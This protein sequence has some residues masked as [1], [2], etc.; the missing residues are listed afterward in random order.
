MTPYFFDQHRFARGFGLFP[1][2]AFRAPAGFRCVSIGG[3][4]LALHA[5]TQYAVEQDPSS[6]DFVLVVGY[7]MDLAAEHD[8]AALVAKTL[9][10]SLNVGEKR[11]FEKLRDLCGRHVIIYRQQ[12][13]VSAVGDACATKAMFY[14]NDRPLLGSH[15]KLVSDLAG[16]GPSEQRLQRKMRQSRRGCYGYAAGTTPDRNVSLLLANMVLR[17]PE[18]KAQRFYP[19]SDL[20]YLDVA[21]AS[22]ELLRLFSVQAALV[23]SRFHVFVSLTAGLD[24][25]VSLSVLRPHIENVRAFSYCTQSAH[26]VDV[27]VAREIAR[28]AGVP[29]QVIGTAVDSKERL[30]AFA[31]VISENNYHR[32]NVVAAYEYLHLFPVGAAHVRSNL[33]EIG[34]AFYRAQSKR[35]SALGPDEMGRLYFRE[36]SRPADPDIYSA[37]AQYAG[38]SNFEGGLFNYDP[39][40]V[41][42]WEQRMSC[43]HAMVVLEADPSVETILMF[44]SRR[45]IELALAVDRAERV[46]G[47]VFRSVI[48]SAWPMLMDFPVN[49][50]AYP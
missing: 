2:G 10:H 45:C 17:L 40:D 38:G 48:Q 46:K 7:V 41:F 33:F 8:E 4:T 44:N 27:R 42:Y 24:S 3:W 31:S 29:Y 37:F 20:P 16:Q 25:R 34:R 5:N 30:K 18:M 14:A 50:K 13:R 28:R 35:P 47:S 21:S 6:G 23:A 22:A 39:Y 43:W 36:Y 49:P 26:E 12:G 11:L 19:S 1:E 32:H 15:F 9:L